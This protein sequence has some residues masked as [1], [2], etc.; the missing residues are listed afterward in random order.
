MLE[1]HD[2]IWDICVCK[3]VNIKVSSQTIMCSIHWMEYII[4]H[5]EYNDWNNTITCN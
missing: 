2:Y 3:I 5:T 4:T 1:C